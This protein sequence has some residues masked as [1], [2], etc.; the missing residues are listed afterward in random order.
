ML[1]STT[2]KVAIDDV[3]LQWFSAR[4]RINCYAITT[5]SRAPTKKPTNDADNDDYNNDETALFNGNCPFECCCTTLRINRRNGKSIYFTRLSKRNWL[6]GTGD[7]TIN[8]SI[9]Q[10]LT[11]HQ[12]LLSQNFCW[13]DKQW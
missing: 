1:L 7:T 13:T 11:Q 3:T 6:N 4:T 12:Y 2:Y 5:S 9:N 10:R 8:R